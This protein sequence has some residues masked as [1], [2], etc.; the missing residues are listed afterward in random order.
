MMFTLTGA[1]ALNGMMAAAG[2]NATIEY[3]NIKHS[4]RLEWIA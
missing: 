3:M 2:K 1:M 4:T